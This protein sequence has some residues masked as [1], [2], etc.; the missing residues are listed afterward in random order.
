MAII[1]INIIYIGGRI[2]QGGESSRATEEK[3]LNFDEKSNALAWLKKRISRTEI[4]VIRFVAFMLFHFYTKKTQ[5][6]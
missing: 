5:Y 6:E 3:V 1:L 4:K 2:S